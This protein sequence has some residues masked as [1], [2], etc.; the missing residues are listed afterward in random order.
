MLLLLIEK[1]LKVHGSSP[2]SQLPTGRLTKQHLRSPVVYCKIDRS[3][4]SGSASD[5]MSTAVNLNDFAPT[6]KIQIS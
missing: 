2:F 1:Y 5:T 6:E 4:V 3:E